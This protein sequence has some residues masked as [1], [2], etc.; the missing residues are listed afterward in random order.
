M[1]FIRDNVCLSRGNYKICYAENVVNWRIPIPIKVESYSSV[2]QQ[3]TSGLS[4][5]VSNLMATWRPIKIDTVTESLDVVQIALNDNRYH[6]R[7]IT[8]ALLT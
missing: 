8:D 6:G 5:N 1:R 3:Q 7:R 2:I 4:L